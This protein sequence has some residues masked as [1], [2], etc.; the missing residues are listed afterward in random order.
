MHHEMKDESWHSHNQLDTLRM[1]QFLNHRI[2]MYIDLIYESEIHGMDES[3]T[4]DAHVTILYQDGEFLSA[5][6]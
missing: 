1:A 4:V 3:Q 6:S 2:C 5:M